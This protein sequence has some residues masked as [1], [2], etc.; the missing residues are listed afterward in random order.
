E[1][2]PW[3]SEDL[4]AKWRNLP[5]LEVPGATYFVTFR[6][7][8]VL[9]PAAREIVLEELCA[10]D[11]KRIDLEAAVVMPDHAHLILRLIGDEKLSRNLKLI[12]G[13]TSRRFNLLLK[14]EGRLWIEESFDR[15]IR[16]EEEL[17]EK[18]EYIRQNPV[19]RSLASYPAAY[20]WLVLRSKN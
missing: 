19:K 16:C 5:H 2:Y 3:T 8:I 7:T 13:R 18:I 17:E 1:I 12:K 14:R 10:C 15:I 11:R 20:K 6:S 9:A 4:I